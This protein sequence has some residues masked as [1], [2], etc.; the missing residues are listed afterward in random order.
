MLDS[1]SLFIAGWST[2]TVVRHDLYRSCKQ[3]HKPIGTEGRSDSLAGVVGRG[4]LCRAEAY[5]RLFTSEPVMFVLF[6]LLHA[7]SVRVSQRNSSKCIAQFEQ[8]RQHISRES[9]QCKKV[10]SQMVFQF[11]QTNNGKR[12]HSPHQSGQAQSFLTI[13]KTHEFLSLDPF[14]PSSW[15]TFMCSLVV[16]ALFSDQRTVTES[17]SLS[18]TTSSENCLAVYQGT[19]TGLTFFTS[20]VSHAS[21][22]FRIFCANKLLRDFDEKLPLQFHLLSVKSCNMSCFVIGEAERNSDTTLALVPAHVNSKP[23]APLH[24]E[25]I[26]TVRGRSVAN[27]EDG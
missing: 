16:C 17:S 20:P 23:S 3:E 24:V 25:A 7:G 12:T 26:I 13:P 4:E 5:G 22:I 27:I 18:T 11:T 9:T 21:R 6:C 2:G 1:G 10:T 19:T 15:T 8:E 14:A